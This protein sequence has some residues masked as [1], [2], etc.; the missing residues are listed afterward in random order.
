MTWRS[1]LF[2]LCTGLLAAAVIL[3]ANGRWEETPI[4]LSTPRSNPGI[5]V[6]VQGPVA[7]PGVYV[8]TPG[9]ILK[10]AL[11]AAG[12]LLPDADPQRLNLASSLQDGQEIRVPIKPTPMPT[13]IFSSA[14]VSG[15]DTG[16]A[17]SVKIN[18]NTAT[19]EELDS[20]PGIG[21]ALAQRIIE[22][23]ETSGPFQNADD[24]LKVKGIGQ[25]LLE[26]IRDQVEAP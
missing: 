8:V 3:I 9:S 11:A 19:L 16:A 23:R 20:L 2:G 21:P 14:P 7:Q 13:S 26:K 12:G 24:L 6:S 5:R 17:P 15:M 25:S 10:D 1:F 4:I 22:Y 18:L